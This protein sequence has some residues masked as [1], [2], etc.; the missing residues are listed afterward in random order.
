MRNLVFFAHN[1]GFHS[2]E[3]HIINRAPVPEVNGFL[4]TQNSKNFKLDR[5][6]V[7]Q[8]F[9]QLVVDFVAS[10]SFVNGDDELVRLFNCQLALCI[11]DCLDT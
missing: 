2:I 4:K 11:H 9:V 5:G 7:I 8:H 1:P 10:H 6:K 3:H